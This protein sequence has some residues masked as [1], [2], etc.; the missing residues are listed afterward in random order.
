VR[1]LRRRSALAGAAAA[2]CG[3]ARHAAA[4]AEE[5]LAGIDRDVPGHT[6]Y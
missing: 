2:L 3:A 4:D 1:E 5:R 6:F